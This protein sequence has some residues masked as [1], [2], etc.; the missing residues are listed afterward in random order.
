FRA[1]GE[2]CQQD[3]DDVEVDA[4]RWPSLVIRHTQVWNEPRRPS[5]T[6]WRP[7]IGRQL[8][9]LPM[10]SIGRPIVGMSQYAAPTSASQATYFSHRLFFPAA[11]LLSMKCNRSEN[12]KAR[13]A[14]SPTE[15]NKSQPTTRMKKLVADC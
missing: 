7:L 15:R 13:E 10:N 3:E 4:H 1:G 12:A 9:H 5:G 8:V 2:Q 6:E 11:I 14:D